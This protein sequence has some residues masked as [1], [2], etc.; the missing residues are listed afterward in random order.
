MLFATF[1][2]KLGRVATFGDLQGI[3]YKR[4]LQPLCYSEAVYALVCPGKSLSSLSSLSLTILLC[5]FY[6]CCFYYYCYYFI[7]TDLYKTITSLSFSLLLSLYISFLCS[8]LLLTV[9]CESN[10]AHTVTLAY[11][12]LL[13]LAVW[14]RSNPVH[15][16]TVVYSCLGLSF[17][18]LLLTVW[19]E[20][21]PAHTI[22]V[23]YLSLLLLAVWCRSNPVHTDTVVYSYCLLSFLE[24]SLA[25]YDDE[26][27]L[28]VGALCLI[29]GLRV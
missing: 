19:C 4:R 26:L 5:Y 18:L 1:L 7:V 8:L 22:T 6:Y 20:S 9:W 12:S 29:I 14:C 2:R 28:A 24:L 10:P 11:F 25:G 15:T 16:D 3:W 13:L 27:L 21:N 17:S 23:V